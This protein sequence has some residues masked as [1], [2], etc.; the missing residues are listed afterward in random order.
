MTVYFQYGLIIVPDFLNDFIIRLHK[1]PE[2]YTCKQYN[3]V[4]IPFC[5]TIQSAVLE[6][7]P[8]QRYTGNLNGRNNG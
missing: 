6:V 3:F 8:C 4:V 2:G 1:V 7:P 5:V